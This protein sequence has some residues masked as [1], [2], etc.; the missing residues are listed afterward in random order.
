[1]D[2]IKKN[3]RESSGRPSRRF[4]YLPLGFAG[5]SASLIVVARLPPFSSRSSTEMRSPT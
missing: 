3:V 2:Y 5:A 1:L 4:V